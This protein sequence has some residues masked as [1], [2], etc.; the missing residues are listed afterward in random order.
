MSYSVLFYFYYL[1]RIMVKSGNMVPCKYVSKL[2]SFFRFLFPHFRK[3]LLVLALQKKG[4]T[5]GLGY[6]LYTCEF[7]DERACY[8]IIKRH[9]YSTTIIVNI[10]AFH[11]SHHFNSPLN[12]KFRKSTNV[13]WQKVFWKGLCLNK[14]GI[15]C[16]VRTPRLWKH[17]VA[18]E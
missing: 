7:E 14:R 12:S 5:L 9:D 16:S 1:E 15:Q 6:F 8:L 3:V 4:P 17:E 18:P 13:I 10:H 2:I 11:S